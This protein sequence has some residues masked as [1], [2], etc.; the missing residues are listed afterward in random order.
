MG[1]FV[2]TLVL[3]TD[4][5]GNP[6]FQELLKQVRDIAL[7]AYENQDVPFER[8]VEELQPERDLS[9][10]PLFQAMFVMQNTPVE[11]VD[12]PELKIRRTEIDSETAKFDLTMFVTDKE[13]E[14]LVSLEYNT[15]LFDTATIERMASHFCC[16][17][18]SIVANPEQRVGEL[19]LLTQEEREWMLSEWNDTEEEFPQEPVHERFA[20][21][22]QQMPEQTAVEADG[23]TFTYREL[24]DRSEGL[25]HFLRREGVG[26]DV[27]VGIC[28]ERSVEM[29]VGLLAS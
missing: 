7:Q 8:L 26:P 14:L 5:S 24:N 29:M 28:M 21:I 27:L 4:F 22:A 1:F 20:A 12:A 11:E 2:N 18:R 3:R 17:L 9:Y 25:A 16:L 13:E 23:V 10:S 15:D 19:P 6:T